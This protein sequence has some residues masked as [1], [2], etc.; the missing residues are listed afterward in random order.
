MDNISLRYDD[1]D[2]E[3]IP[4]YFSRLLNEF[5]ILLKDR[6]TRRTPYTISQIICTNMKKINEEEFEV[7]TFR[8]MIWQCVV[9]SRDV[10]PL[11]F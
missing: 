5:S 2:F 8:I 10:H 9:T 3:S 4:S 11:R 7:G 1:V 6:T